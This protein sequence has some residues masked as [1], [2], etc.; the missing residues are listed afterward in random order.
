MT[1]DLNEEDGGHP[2]AAVEAAPDANG[3][4][5]AI[6]VLLE[7]LRHGCAPV[8]KAPPAPVNKAVDLLHDLAAL[9]RA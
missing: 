7:S 1:G 9:S 4:Q 8:D 5:R 6:Q 3:T 2:E